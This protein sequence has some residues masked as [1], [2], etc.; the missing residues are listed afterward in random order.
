ML[1]CRT[2]TTSA[3]ENHI[4]CCVQWQKKFRALITPLRYTLRYFVVLPH[5]PGTLH[6]DEWLQ[7]PS[8]PKSFRKIN[9][10]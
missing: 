2:P 9:Q 4:P 1:A 10:L 5:T 8:W 7:T 3:D 6:K